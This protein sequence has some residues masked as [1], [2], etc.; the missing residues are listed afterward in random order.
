MIRRVTTFALD[1]I[2][3]RPWWVD[4]DVR[5]GVP[6][7]T[8]LGVGDLALHE[9]RERVRRAIVGQGFDFPER[10]IVANI[11]APGAASR[12]GPQ[13]EL[14]LAA[15]ILAD[16]DEVPRPHHARWAVFGRLTETGTL[17]PA[18][19]TL[20]A[21]EA[22]RA[23]GVAGLI[24]PPAAAREAALVDGLEIASADDLRAVCSVLAR[25]PSI[26]Y[27]PLAPAHAWGETDFEHASIA[28]DA[29]TL[30]ALEVAAAGGHS[31][32]IEAPPGGVDPAAVAAGLPSLLPALHSDEALEV[33]RIRSAAGLSL[34]SR[35]IRRP[36]SAPAPSVSIPGLLGGATPGAVT[37]AHRGVLLLE[38]LPA[39]EAA[40]L[41]QH[42][43]QPLAEGS[44]TLIRG[45]EPIRYPS[46]FL[47]VATL[48]GAA[49]EAAG[50]R[51][52]V[53]RDLFDIRVRLPWP[54]ASSA[55]TATYAV[56]ERVELGRATRPLS[57]A[58]VVDR[59]GSR[60]CVSLPLEAARPAALSLLN[61]IEYPSD[62]RRVVRVAFTIAALAE[63]LVIDVDDV[64]EALA[65]TTPS[66]P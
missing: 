54:S 22:A 49:E 65:L 64:D 20:Q 18:R 9:T 5:P 21:A 6:G 35:R 57:C 39:F 24:V 28:A 59:R 40:K 10:R 61:R 58:A 41:L 42:L 16:S 7:F 50:P 15:A 32:L 3:A 47:L 27:R 23:E 14:A 11:I 2:H 25:T 34:P 13:A 43:H 66:A 8:I 26:R 1:G 29:R 36:L 62:W 55:P 19:G 37:L 63:R 56:R 52:G 51:E 60:E 46:R 17:A 30:R 44:T 38:D 45:R 53:R 4:V 48:I 31:L 33:A 12:T